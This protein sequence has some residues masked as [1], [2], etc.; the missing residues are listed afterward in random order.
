MADESTSTPKQDLTPADEKEYVY[1]AYAKC[2]FCGDHRI[3]GGSI[4]IEQNYAHQE[5][6]CTECG[7]EWSDAYRLEGLC[8]TR[9]PDGR[10]YPPGEYPPIDGPHCRRCGTDIKSGR[11]SDV[12]CPFSDYPQD[13]PR[14]WAGHP[15]HDPEMQA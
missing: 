6:S 5:V 10:D 15:E 13:D 12:T 8:V 2:P 14:G 9:T 11:C 3:E 7:A 1:R 4:E